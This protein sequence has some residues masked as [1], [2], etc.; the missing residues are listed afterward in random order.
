M[1]SRA[2]P[3]APASLVADER[4]SHKL[5]RRKLGFRAWHRG[6][7]EADLLIGAFSDQCLAQF[8]EEELRQF[9]L[10]LEEDDPVIDDWMAG[11]RPVPKEHDNKVMTLLREF[12]PLRTHRR[13][14]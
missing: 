14:E 4:E 12:R 1:P 10:L 11:R 8:A 7:C 5:L 9:E 3:N 2:T 6:T 13:E